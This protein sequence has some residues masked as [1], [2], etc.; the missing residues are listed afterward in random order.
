MND[1]S[2]E[3]DTKALLTHDVLMIEGH[4]RGNMGHPLPISQH[5]GL[6]LPVPEA[7]GSS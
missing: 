2:P 3:H 4:A 6:I 7:G 5:K 1:E